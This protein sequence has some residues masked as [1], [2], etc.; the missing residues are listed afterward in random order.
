MES[1][2]LWTR[3][4]AEA[5]QIA[6]NRSINALH[7]YRHRK[8]KPIMTQMR[9]WTV[10]NHSMF[11]T[12]SGPAVV[13]TACIFH[14]VIVADTGATVSIVT[15]VAEFCM[16]R[17]IQWAEPAD[18]SLETDAHVRAESVG[19]RSSVDALRGIKQAFV[20]V[21]FTLPTCKTKLNFYRLSKRNEYRRVH[22]W[23]QTKARQKQ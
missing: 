21:F 22:I 13:T 14:N 9:K 16:A 10:T 23:D 1:G 19:A 18:V 6:R 17:I 11:T 20:N 4:I 2:Q 5:V 7:S 12:D 8:R 3:L 15:A